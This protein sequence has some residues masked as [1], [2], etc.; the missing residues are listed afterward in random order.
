MVFYYS[1]W[2]LRNFREEKR[3]RHSLTGLVSSIFKIIV[4]F[5]HSYVSE[6]FCIVEIC[7]FCMLLAIHDSYAIIALNYRFSSIF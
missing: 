6:G 2:F 5:K 3:I 1:I 4:L 7:I